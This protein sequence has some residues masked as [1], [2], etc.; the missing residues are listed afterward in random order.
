MWARNK[1]QFY[2]Q[3]AE[4]YLQ[5]QGLQALQKNY[6]CRMGEIDLIMLDQDCLC[7][8]EVKF[9]KNDAFGGAAYSIPPSK[10]R[11]IIQTALHFIS[12]KPLYQQSPYRFDAVFIQQHKMFKNAQIEW[13]KSAFDGE[14]Y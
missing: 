6:H 10:Q 14:M 12:R 3:Q 2:E 7:F 11:K 13:I 1:G 9:R 4:E 5:Q 8:I